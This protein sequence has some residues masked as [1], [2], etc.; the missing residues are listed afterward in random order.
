MA[1][2]PNAELLRSVL[3]G[4]L[5]VDAQRLR[6][7]LNTPENED[8]IFRPLETGGVEML[9][10]YTEGMARDDKIADFIIRACR[11]F[12]AQSDA[13]PQKR[14]QNLLKQAIDIPQA[15]LENRLGALVEQILGGMS[16]LVIDGCPEAL[17]LETR[18][19]EKRPVNRT[20]SESVVVG[21]QEG[22]VESL[23]TNLTLMRR[24]V[25]SP[26]LITEMTTV[27]TRVPLRVAMMY[28]KGVAREETLAQMR[29]RVKSVTAAAVQGLGQLEQLIEDNPWALVPQMLLT[30]RP[31]R[32]A[33]CVLD[34]QIVLLA[35]GSPYALVAPATL[36]HLLH[37]SDDSFMRWQYGSFLRFIRMLGAVFSLLLPGAYVALT[38]YHPHL[39]PMALLTAIAET[40]AQVPFSALT[41]VLLMEFSF[42]L[43]NEASTRIPS[44]MGSIIGIVGGLIL[45]QA[46]VSASIIS[47]IVIIVVALTGLGNFALPGYGFTVGMTILRIA[48]I[49]VS[50]A[51][52]LYGLILAAFLLLCHLCSLRS[53]GVPFMAPVAPFRPHNPDILLRLPIWMQKRLLFLS[54]R[55]SWMRKE[56]KR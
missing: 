26:A 45:G 19:F 56:G 2:M 14:A 40:R 1:E 28:M 30:E 39:I 23:R 46:A 31:D 32:A 11:A 41:E 37:A 25:Q 22:F 44:Q 18:G 17:L 48:V 5:T 10:V 34:G 12:D 43:I 7:I 38:L 51:F 3:T 27:G 24:Y 15:R 21:A 33:S 35:D 36:F 29:G 8:I 49:L 4:V 16:A 13:A 42:Y 52:G 6:T 20:F 9:V 53:L 47:P 54:R 50:A 55:D